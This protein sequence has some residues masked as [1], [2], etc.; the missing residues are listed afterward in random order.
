MANFHEK[1]DWENSVVD[2]YAFCLN[3]ISQGSGKVTTHFGSN[4]LS[5]WQNNPPP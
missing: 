2:R 5:L 4:V 3:W 1:K